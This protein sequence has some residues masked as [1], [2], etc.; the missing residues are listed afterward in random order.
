MRKLG[1]SC[2]VSFE[3][4]EMYDAF[5]K[6]MAFRFINDAAIREALQERGVVVTVEEGKRGRAKFA[7]YTLER[8]PRR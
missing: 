3:L 6:S 5:H 7:V 4:S 2:C 8:T 1:D